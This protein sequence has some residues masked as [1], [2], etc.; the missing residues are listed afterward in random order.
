MVDGTYIQAHQSST[1]ARKRGRTPAQ[2]R[3]T[4]AIGRRRGGLTPKLW[5]LGDKQGRFV[6]FLLWPGHTAEVTAF[7]ALLAA[8][9]LI[10]VIPP[11]VHRK[12]RDTIPCN[13]EAYKARHLLANAFADRKHFRGIAHRTC[14]LAA[15]FTGLRDLVSWFLG[16]RR[17]AQR[18]AC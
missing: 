16:I 6:R 8:L 11:R 18:P 9:G 10:A 2:S 14:K 12:D 4:Q 5:A 17:T 3:V 13:R 1:G 7:A 15:T